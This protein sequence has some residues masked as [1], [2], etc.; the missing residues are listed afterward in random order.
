M[1]VFRGGIVLV[2]FFK[3]L[4]LFCGLSL[5]KCRLCIFFSP[6]F[7]LLLDEN[8]LMYEVSIKTIPTCLPSLHH[9]FFKKKKKKEKKKG[10]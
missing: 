7:F 8:F 1:D 4:F 5:S 3:E 6:F 9:I 2:L 10:C